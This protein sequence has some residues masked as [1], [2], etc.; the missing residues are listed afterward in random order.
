MNTLSLIHNKS[1]DYYQKLRFKL[2]DSAP[3]IHPFFPMSFNMSAGFVQLDPYIRGKKKIENEKIVTFQK[4]I[5]YFDRKH[6]G[7]DSTHLSFFEMFGALTIGKPDRK[8]LIE[9]MWVFLTEKLKIDKERII[10]SVFQ[11]D[12]IRGKEFAADKEME[13]IW[14]GVGLKKPQIY[15]GDKDNVFWFQ[16]GNKLDDKIKGSPFANKLCGYQTELFFDTKKKKCSKKCNI[17][18]K[19]GKYIE[20]ANNLTIEYEFNPR[21]NSFRKL[22]IPATETVFGTERLAAVLEDKTGIWEASIFKNTIL[23][24]DEYIQLSNEDQRIMIDRLRALIFL[25]I[26]GIPEPGHNGRRRIVR[27]YMRDVLSRAYKI[28]EDESGIEKII[29]L[30]LKKIAA[31]YIEFYPNIKNAVKYCSQAILA[32]HKKYISTIHH[33]KESIKHSLLRGDV[34]EL[35]SDTKLM[36]E[37]KLG[38]PTFLIDLFYGDAFTPALAVKENRV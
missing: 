26:E 24:E 18:C 31:S 1:I 19:C 11:G 2:Q 14:Q 8:Q 25:A 10:V 6:S 23:P 32:H 37:K 36:L 22:D 9:D 7:K 38:I 30:Y 16:G 34:K 35:D 28:E 27:H 5:R 3:L 13:K 29:D 12:N 21:T 15:Y 20:I 33:T 4:C 17:F